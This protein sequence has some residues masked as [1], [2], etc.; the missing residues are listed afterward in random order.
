MRL[1]RNQHAILV[2]DDEGLVAELRQRAERMQ[3]YVNDVADMTWGDQAVY[4]RV[5]HTLNEAAVKIEAACC[6]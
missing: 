2:V 5:I 6:G 1:S 3:Q 4:R